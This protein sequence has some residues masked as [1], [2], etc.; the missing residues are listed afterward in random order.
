MKS[1]RYRLLFILISLCLSFSGLQAQEENESKPK[2]VFVHGYLKDMVSL[3]S[4]NSELYV[5]NLVHNRI[6]LHWAPHKNLSLYA[7]MRNRV[8]FGDIVNLYP[9]Y[10]DIIDTNNDY[11]DLSFHIVDHE[12]VVVNSVFDRLYLEWIK[13]DWEIRIGRQRVNWG[14]NIVWN[15]NDLFN[16]FSFFDFDYEER[17]GAD[18][19]RVTKYFGF[20]SSLEVAAKMADTKEELTAAALWKFNKLGYDFQL[21]GGVKEGDYVAG[22][23]WAGNIKNAGFKG[24][25][26]YFHPWEVS[27]FSDTVFTGSIS[28]DYSFA[29]GFYVLG[30][31]LYNSDPKG[32]L[33]LMN[34]SVELSSKNLMPY[35]HSLM[36]QGSY[37]IHP[38]VNTSL[39]FMAFPGENSI[40]INPSV[41]YSAKENLDIG[42]FSQILL[43]DPNGK[44]ETILQSYFLRVNWSF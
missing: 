1:G 40:F 29:N 6:N 17:P 15:P 11:F 5:D 26:S 19:V 42:L 24:E 35:T 14:T 8:F 30:S 4:F 10:A 38:L 43:D 33:N 12:K 20:A 44:L 39:G 21:I 28:V 36:L 31:W 37:P 32:N 16:A 23:G 3:Y 18:A 27:V 34:S 9:N 25:L 22:L 7:G 2:K 13:G 41:S